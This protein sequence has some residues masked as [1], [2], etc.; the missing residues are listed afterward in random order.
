MLIFDFIILPS[1][2]K[3]L[4]Y[5]P[6]NLHIN[7]SFLWG[8]I[9][10]CLTL[11][12]KLMWLIPMACLSRIVNSLWFQEIADSAYRYRKGRPHFNFTFST[13]IAD[14]VFS[15]GVQFL[16]LGQVIVE[17]LYLLKFFSN[18]SCYRPRYII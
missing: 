18:K 11:F 14:T 5:L 15:V 9:E 7:K 10:P 4:N 16:F 6:D 8:Y 13:F 1:A 12:F 3:S 2:N 17:R